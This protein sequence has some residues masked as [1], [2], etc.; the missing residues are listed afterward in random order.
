MSINPVMAK[1][2]GNF[3]LLERLQNKPNQTQFQMAELGTKKEPLSPTDTGSKTTG[4]GRI[5]TAE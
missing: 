2:Y 1:H 3:H 4:G 5:R